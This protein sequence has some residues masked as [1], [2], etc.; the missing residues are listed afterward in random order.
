[1]K[2][3]Q[4]VLLPPTLALVG[5]AVFGAVVL[6][7]HSLGR[8]ALEDIYQK[9]FA[10]Y[11][12]VG[13]IS[14]ALDG[15][16][17]GVYR[18]VTWIGNYD[19][20]KLAERLQSLTDQI[21]QVSAAL[22]LLRAQ[23]EVSVSETNHLQKLLEQVAAYRKQLSTAV[24]LA[25]SDVSM[26]LSALQT[27]D[28]TFQNLRKEL[29]ALIEVEHGYAEQHY[30]RATRAY[31]SAVVTAVLVLLVAALL[32]AV[33]ATLVTRSVVRQLGGEP[34]VAAR[35]AQ[36][37]AEGKLDLDIV[38]RPNDSTSLLAVLRT[39]VARLSVVVSEVRNSA[40]GLSAASGQ[41]S[42]TAQLLSQGTSEQS[43]AVEE[44]SAS[45]EEMSASIEQT[46]ENGHET[47]Q[48][49]S[50]GARDA[51]DSGQSVGQTVAAMKA[52]AEKIS[53]INE[54]AYQTNLLALNAAIEA[55]R[56]GEHG[57]GF[58][59]VAS[60][61]RKLAETSQAAAREISGLALSSVGLA[62]RTGERLSNLVPSIERTATLVRETTTASTQQAA[63][64]RQLNSAMS[65][66]SQVTQRNAAAAE[67][68]SATAEE[69]AAQAEALSE[70]VGY[71]VIG[72][73][74]RAPL[75]GPAPTPPLLPRA[76]ARSQ[77]ARSASRSIS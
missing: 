77:R 52:I 18:L 62:E 38:T 22:R 24:D 68:L 27:A 23:P 42:G 50:K 8:D 75:T 64:V 72:E 61:V 66:V 63:S 35:I 49:A 17:A 71:F 55:A 12:K 4:R 56:A 3:H 11:Q 74:G 58:A 25:S 36:S 48:A 43:A 6:R 59:V 28:V 60:E 45:L 30:G 31:E 15:V 19:E 67:E 69:M 5:L 21:E 70:R 32:A 65:Q 26:G 34:E 40:A 44:T 53:I 76:P 37:V 57:R 73:R 29:D 14:S 54:I 7:A 46:A 10:A 51:A 47:E 20:A 16:H 41:V 1:M 33:T 9:R 39:M 13:D 2:L